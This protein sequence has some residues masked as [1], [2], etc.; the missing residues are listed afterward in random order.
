MSTL[1]VLIGLN[2][3]TIR[4]M[5]K[6]INSFVK[7]KHASSMCKGKFSQLSVS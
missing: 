6:V 7:Q 1:K 4:I 5:S 3:L 2:T